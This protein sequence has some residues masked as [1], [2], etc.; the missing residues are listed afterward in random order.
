MLFHCEVKNIDIEVVLVSAITYVAESTTC[1]FYMCMIGLNIIHRE[2]QITVKPQF[3]RPTFY[4]F[5]HFL[6]SQPKPYMPNVLFSV[7]QGLC[8]ILLMKLWFLHMF[9]ILSLWPSLC[10]SRSSSFVWHAQISKV[11][12]LLMCGTHLGCLCCFCSKPLASLLCV[13]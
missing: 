4:I 10:N 11:G 2:M 3:K 13:R 12:I 6:W 7:I 9:W 8:W 5:L 1:E